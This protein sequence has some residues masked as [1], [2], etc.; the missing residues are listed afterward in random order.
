[1]ENE[2]RLI[3]TVEK[4]FEEVIKTK[5]KKMNGTIVC[6]RRSGNK[7]DVIHVCIDKAQNLGFKKGDRVE[8]KG[9]T[10]IYP[11]HSS[12]DDMDHYYTFVIADSITITE[13]V[14]DYNYVKIAGEIG[15]FCKLRTTPLGKTI[16]DI[17]LKVEIPMKS[18]DITWEKTDYFPCIVWEKNAEKVFEAKG[19]NPLLVTFEG[20]IQSRNFVKQYEDGKAIFRTVSEIS[21]LRFKL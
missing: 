16:C 6:K 1:M 20:M 11:I 5:G 8:V 12:E 15:E 3:G 7:M 9:F 13:S 21:V 10:C 17:M 14:D 19:E 2:V 4:E 18:K